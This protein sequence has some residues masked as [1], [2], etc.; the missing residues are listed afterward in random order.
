V[1][2]CTGWWDGWP[3]VIWGIDLRACCAAHDLAYAA[4][5]WTSVVS[6]FEL[7]RCV[8]AAGGSAMGGIMLAGVLTFGA[9]FK[10]HYANRFG[11]RKP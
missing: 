11:R 10:I 5:F 2:A 3:D 9:L 7:G 8:A 6:D 4:G 1:D